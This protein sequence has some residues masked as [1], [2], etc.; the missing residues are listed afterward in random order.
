MSLRHRLVAALVLIGAVLVVAGVVVAGLIRGALIDQVDRQLE[1]AGPPLGTF[2]G[3]LGPGQAIAPRPG[4]TTPND[5][6]TE[7][8]VAVASVEGYRI[9]EQTVGSEPPPDL[10]DVLPPDGA[11]ADP[12]PRFATVAAVGGGHEYRVLVEGMPSGGAIAVAQPLRPT[13]HTWRQIV[14]VEIVAFLTV[15]LTLC[16]MAWWLLHHGVRPIEKMARTANAI[17]DGDLSRRVSPAETTTEVGRLGVALNT[18]LGQ[19]EGAFDEKQASEDR[20]RRFVADASHELRTPLTSIRGYAELWRAGAISTESEQADAMRRVE[21]EAARMGRLVDDMLLLARLDEGRPLDLTDVD[22]ARIAEDAVAD[23]RAVE[24]GRP[25]SLI[26]H[27]AVVVSGD[28]DRLRQVTA[29]LVVNALVHTPPGTAVEVRV[30]RDG[31]TA[32][33]EVADHGPGLPP[34]LATRVFERFVRAD[35]A[36]TRATGGA[37]LGLAIVAAV[38]EAH[39]GRAEV[40]STPGEGAT[41]R[42][43]LPAQVV[44]IRSATSDHA[45]R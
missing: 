14:T 37:G 13:L 21:H 3:A 44:D 34:E 16:M 18:M 39:G 31:S 20:L 43:V 9:F 41:F 33:L 15:L 5:R 27:E 25:I 2:V 29:N 40:E 42:V 4:V 36:R 10:T 28:A 22:L 1:R 32:V 11:L 17:A 8:Y 30:R 38:V 24:P 26:A 7:L 23:A 6:F 19:I 45:L 35:P 12:S